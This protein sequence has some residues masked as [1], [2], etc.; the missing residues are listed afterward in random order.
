MPQTQTKPEADA[1][2]AA[3]KKSSKKDDGLTPAV[4]AV[5]WARVKNTTKIPG[6]GGSNITMQKGK[7]VSNQ[8]YDFDVLK[9]AG[10]E[11]E[12]CEAPAWW[13]TMQKT[14]GSLARQ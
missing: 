5:K 10:V 3:A 7:Q 12:P 8:G 13:I 14:G 9:N 2:P 6:P 1:V 11:L 4:R